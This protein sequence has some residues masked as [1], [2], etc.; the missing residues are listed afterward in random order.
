MRLCLLWGIRKPLDQDQLENAENTPSTEI[1]ETTWQ[2]FPTVRIYRS[3]E[4]SLAAKKLRDDTVGE[5][6]ESQVSLKRTNT[7]ES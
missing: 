3:Q 4:E 5:L 1:K 6:V 2:P 7:A